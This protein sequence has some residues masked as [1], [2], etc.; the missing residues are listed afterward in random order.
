MTMCH[1]S[2]QRHSGLQEQGTG[3]AVWFDKC[4]HIAVTSR[5]SFDGQWEGPLAQ[6]VAVPAAHTDLLPSSSA[7]RKRSRGISRIGCWVVQAMGARGQLGATAQKTPR[8]FWP[9]APPIHLLR[10]LLEHF[11]VQQSMAGRGDVAAVGASG[12]R[13]EAPRNLLLYSPFLD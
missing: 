13:S 3:E 4:L 7:T 9:P 8:A 1:V 6:H 5:N 2:D 12:E 10:S 11:W